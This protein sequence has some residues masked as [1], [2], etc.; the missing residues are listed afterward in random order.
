MELWHCAQTNAIC[1]LTGLI[2]AAAIALLSALFADTV[3]L[4]GVAGGHEA[5]LAADLVLE[6]ANFGREKF[7]RGATLGAHHVV[8]AAPVV[9]MLVAGDAVVKCNFAGQAATGQ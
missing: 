9:L 5:M 4:K 6:L 1:A 7:H 2:G 3:N 8:M